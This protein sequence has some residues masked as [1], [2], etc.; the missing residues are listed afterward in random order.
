M[1]FKLRA[2]N[3]G[4]IKSIQEIYSFYVEFEICTF[5]EEIP[6]EDEI[7][8]RY[9]SITGNGYPYIVA[10]TKSADESSETVVGYAYA[11]AFRPRI[12]YRYTVEDSIYI[13]KDYKGLGVGK[14][15]LSE[16]IKLCKEKGY[17]Q[18]V[19]V[20][21]G[22]ENV[23]SIVLHEKLGFGNKSHLKDVG[24]KFDKFID[25]VTLQLAL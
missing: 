2:A 8:K 9:K 1:E 13:S 3:E 12:A 4:D 11:S 22:F 21:G 6:S 23:G 25:T 17:K 16:L 7:L 15:L 14:L 10:T 24:F 5:E 18:M 20:I 19:A